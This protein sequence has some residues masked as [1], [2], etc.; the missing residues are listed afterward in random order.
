MTHITAMKNCEHYPVDMVLTP[1][2][3]HHGKYL[4][5]ACGKF[6]GWAKKPATLELEVQN[7]KIIS[8]LKN[9]PVTQWEKQFLL[10]LEKQGGRFS[11]K[12]KSLLNSL[13]LRY[14]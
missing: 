1:E 6:M 11:P 7:S 14:V 2:L 10:S 5:H 4:C 3:T 12:Q 8:D 13:K 9:K